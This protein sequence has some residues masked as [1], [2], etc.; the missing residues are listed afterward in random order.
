MTG[1]VEVTAWVTSTVWVTGVE[2]V[3]SD[4]H[5]GLRGA[6]REVFSE[7]VWQRCY[8]HFLRNALDHLPRKAD[9]E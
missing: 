1:T 6:I 2:L 7:A 3:I 4:D 9:D 8:V 5:P